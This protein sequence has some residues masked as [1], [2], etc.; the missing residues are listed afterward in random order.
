[1]Q[2]K[3]SLYEPVAQPLVFMG[4]PQADEK[5]TLS[6]TVPPPLLLSAF[7]SPLLSVFLS[8]LLSPPPSLFALY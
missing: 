2:V 6:G 4:K 5:K 8:L 1:M 7:L 3:E